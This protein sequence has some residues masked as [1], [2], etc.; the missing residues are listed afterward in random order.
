MQ[1]KA[2]VAP[3]TRADAIKREQ[4]T[5]ASKEKKKEKKRKQLEPSRLLGAGVCG[6][7]KVLRRNLFTDGRQLFAATRSGPSESV[8]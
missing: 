3:G 6:K 7:G 4:S 5:E 1:T 2:A 8:R